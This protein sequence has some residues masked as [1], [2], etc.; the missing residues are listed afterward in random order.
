MITA[1]KLRIGNKLSV[2]NNDGTEGAIGSVT[3]IVS[4]CL[5]V[6]GIVYTFDKVEPV[7]LTVERLDKC[8]FKERAS[9]LYEN[10]NYHFHIT[11]EGEHFMVMQQS[12]YIAEPIKYMHE[13]QN[14]VFAL[15]KEELRVIL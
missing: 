14:I 1:N 11:K 4:D 2:I 8:G 5:R 6:N 3:E 13:L 15:T 7:L 10:D 12:L 9:Q